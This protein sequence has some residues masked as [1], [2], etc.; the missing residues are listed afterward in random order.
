M[1][2]CVCVYIYIYIYRHVSHAD[3]TDFPESL[4]PSLSSIA[5]GRSSRRHA[6]FAQ[7]SCVLVLVGRSTL[8]TSI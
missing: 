2:V 3:S 8:G 7:S 5:L 6:V 1:C 4:H